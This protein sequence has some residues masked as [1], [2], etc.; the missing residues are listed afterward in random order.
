MCQFNVTT[1]TSAVLSEINGVFRYDNDSAAVMRL[2]A[3]SHAS[4]QSDCDAS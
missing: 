4:I 3:Q 2:H 1:V